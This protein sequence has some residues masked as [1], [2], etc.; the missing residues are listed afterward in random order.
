MNNLELLFAPKTVAIVGVSENPT[1][2]GS[3]LLSNLIEARFTGKIYPV[4]PKHQELYGFKVYH[5]VAEIPESVDVVC[6][7]VP[8]PFVKQSIIDSVSNKAKAA[9][10]ISAGFKETGSAGAQLEEEIRVIAKQ[11]NLTIL[12]PN[13]LGVITPGAKVNLSFAASN[14]QEGNIGFLSQSGAFCTA[15]LDMSI[16]TNL[17]FSHFLSLGNKADLDEN[18]IIDF[19]IKQ[20]EVKVIGAYLEEIKDGQK[21]L[22]VVKNN[23]ENKPVIVFK[24]G[25]TNQ[26]RIAITSHTGALAGSVKTVETALKQAGII[27][28]NE[29]NEMYNLMMSFS[30]SKYPAGKRIAIITNAG[31]PGIMATDELITSGLVLAEISEEAKTKMKEFLPVTASVNNPIDVIGDALA[32]RYKV[33]ID[34]VI[35]DPNVDAILIILTPQLVTQIEDTAKLI[36]NSAKLANKPIFAVFIGGKY[37]ANGLQRLYDNKVPAFRYIRDAIQVI[38]AMYE[39]GQSIKENAENPNTVS[40]SRY[41]NQGKYRSEILTNYQAGIASTVPEKLAAKLADEVG[42]DL[43]KQKVCN[44]VDEAIAF[45]QD[46]FPVVVKAPT[47]VIAHKTDEKALYLNL[48]NVESLRFSY[49]ELEK[50]IHNKFNIQAPQL[51]VQEQIKAKEELLI[52]ASRDGDSLVYQEG[53]AGFGHLLTFGKGGIYTEIYHDIAHALVPANRYTILQALQRTKIYQIIQ[54]ARGLNPLAFEQVIN[55]IEAVQQLVLLYPEI[56]SLDINPLL[57][58]ETRAVAV[59]FKIFLS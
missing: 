13:C 18:A 2:L 47:E 37:V 7:A 41:L 50:M 10:I 17:G 12:G 42:I 25:K 44:S 34:I 9:I 8:A 19:W 26:A 56:A 35:K 23:P 48:D 45:A 43:P 54:G 31:G 24:P 5:S 6:I 39:F 29:I 49:L 22:A 52:G 36:I 28:V 51:L 32:E 59:D 15:I 58:T 3:V 53:E 46:K 55:T 57:V 11:G 16:D 38:H 40:I 30:W 27:E 20:P 33:P 14:P 4:N 1:K 21:L